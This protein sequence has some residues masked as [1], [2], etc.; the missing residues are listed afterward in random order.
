MTTTLVEAHTSFP[1]PVRAED[2]VRRVAAILTFDYVDKIVL[3]SGSGA[4]DVTW[5][6]GPNDVMVLSD[7]LTWDLD[8]LQDLDIEDFTAFPTL[9]VTFFEAITH[10]YESEQHPCC[11]LV[12]SIAEFRQCLG[13]DPGFRFLT[14]EGRRPVYLGLPIFVDQRLQG[15]QAAMLLLHSSVKTDSPNLCK[16]ALRVSMRG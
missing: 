14:D 7:S 5:R 16:Q 11:I 12:P 3:D 6:R 15:S 1:M 8:Y 9:R 10:I 2:V 4:I 13:L